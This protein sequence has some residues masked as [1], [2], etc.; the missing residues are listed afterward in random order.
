M[1][2][3]PFS[4]QLTIF[5]HLIHQS[6]QHIEQFKYPPALMRL[7]RLA[8]EKSVIVVANAKAVEALTCEG[9]QLG[10]CFW[11]GPFRF[12]RLSEHR[13]FKKVWHRNLCNGFIMQAVDDY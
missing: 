2:T 3:A 10:P 1:Q 7:V 12:N 8:G 4:G 6:L 11:F 5:A 13:G 9:K